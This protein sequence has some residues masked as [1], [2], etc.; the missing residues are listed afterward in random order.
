MKSKQVL[1]Y[2]DLIKKIESM[3]IVIKSPHQVK[4]TLSNINYQRLMV[5]RLHFLEGSAIKSGTKF[6]DIY[7][8]YQFDR[9]LKASIF[10]LLESLELSLRA[11]IGYH[12]G[13]HTGSHGYLDEINFKEAT[14]HQNM[15]QKYIKAKDRDRQKRISIVKHH[16][17]KYTDELPIYKAIELFTFGELIRLFNNL[18]DMSLKREIIDDYIN[19]ENQLRVKIFRSWVIKLVDIRN[20]CAH[21]DIFW[22]RNFEFR[23]IRN[24]YWNSLGV[25]NFKN[26]QYYS[27]FTIM[28]IFKILTS[29]DSLYCEVLD[30][31]ERIFSKYQHIVTPADIGFPINWKRDLINY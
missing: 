1:T 12:L 10:P 5:Y 14:Y 15:L 30:N 25:F 16:E 9:D 28:I 27:I 18:K 4:E 19:K 26:K 21:Y 17:R 8:L 23:P 7:D 6:E 29:N 31:L 24:S 11:K 22:N 2:P 13:Q 20:I 3:G